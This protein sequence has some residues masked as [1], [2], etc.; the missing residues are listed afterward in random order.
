MNQTNLGSFGQFI[1]G[2][3][4]PKGHI[5]QGNGIP[6]IRYAEIYTSYEEV[7]YSF[8]SH[9]LAEN[10]KEALEVHQGDIIFPTSGETAEEIGKAVA[11]LGSEMAYA[12]G[13]TLV[14]RNHGQNPAYLA[15]ALNEWEAVKQKVRLATGQSVVHLYASELSEV[16]IWLPS[17]AEQERIVEI[18]ADADAVIATAGK[19]AKELNDQFVG[20]R[21]QLIKQIVQHKNSEI[22]L[23]EFS[24]IPDIEAIT[25]AE[26]K[27]LL[28][29]SLHCKGVKTNGG[30]KIR[31]TAK[32]RPYYRRNKG[33]FL[34]GRQNIHNG[35]FGFVSSELGGGI[36][37]NAIT[38][39]RLDSSKISERYFFHYFSRPDFYRRLEVFMGGTGQK[40]M[41][42]NELRRIKM[43]VPDMQMQKEIATTIDA[44]LEAYEKQERL[45]TSLKKQKRGLMQQLLTGKLRVPPKNEIK[46]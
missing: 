31:L 5:T 45:V 41:G 21:N 3:G 12:G 16:S 37:S 14:L 22:A 19:L 43:F 20:F 24:K 44:H 6:C 36:A 26:N 2:K 28:T 13:D 23:G 11:Y 27:T 4:I 15:Y 25:S 35:G 9:I 1:R 33:D 18:L 34:I 29:I 7:T 42:D 10:T 39:L 38:S 32:G 17:L 46:A 40:E 30:R 8:V